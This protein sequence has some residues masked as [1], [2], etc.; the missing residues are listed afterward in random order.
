MTF[1]QLILGEPGQR[2]RKVCPGMVYI[3]YCLVWVVSIVGTPPT[4]DPRAIVTGIA[5]FCG[6]SI[7][8][9]ILRR[10][11]PPTDGTWRQLT[12]AGPFLPTGVG[13]GKAGAGARGARF[14]SHHAV[15]EA[16]AGQ[17]TGCPLQWRIL[18]CMGANLLGPARRLARPADSTVPP[19]RWGKAP[20]QEEPDVRAARYSPRMSAWRCS[21]PW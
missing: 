19:Y 18:A 7:R 5:R 10:F 12:R 13:L 21:R 4:Y 1:C 9:R 8:A 14:G 17:P 20:R 16:Q 15:S 3:N 2:P 6:A 11:H